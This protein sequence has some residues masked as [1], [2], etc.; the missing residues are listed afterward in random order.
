MDSGNGDKR[1]R[2]HDWDELRA[3]VAL[4]CR[5][6]RHFPALDVS[7][8][9]IPSYPGDREL[10]LEKAYGPQVGPAPCHFSTSHLRPA[11]KF[12]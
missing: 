6:V 4:I 7:M 2:R 5:P 1:I 3:F 8:W 11:T 12:I 9:L 10:L